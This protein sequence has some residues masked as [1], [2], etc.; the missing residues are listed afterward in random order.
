MFEAMI[1][2]ARNCGA[3]RIVGEFIR[4][5]K[6][7]YVKELFERLGFDPLV[8]DDNFRP[9]PEGTL[10]SLALSGHSVAEYYIDTTISLRG[11]EETM[12]LSASQ[13]SE[14]KVRLS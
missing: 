4:T 12:K 10:Y 6:N 11:A 2:F 5:E 8:A 14:K 7:V 13:H 3:D 9:E 1:C